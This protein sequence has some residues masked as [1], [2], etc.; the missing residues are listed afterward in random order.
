M[1]PRSPH[2]TTNQPPYALFV[3]LRISSMQPTPWHNIVVGIV[4]HID[5]SDTST[6]IACSLTHP[7]WTLPAQRRLYHTLRIKNREDMCR[8]G[9]FDVRD[10]FTPYVRH[11]IYCGD[12]ENP[13]FP[14]DF[15][16]TCGAK[17]RDF[18][19]HTLEI[20][21]LALERFDVD[22]FMLVFGH[23]R[24]TLRALLIRDATLTLN[25][26]LEFLNLFPLLQCLGLDRFTVV[27][28]PSPFP[29]QRPIFQG[30]LNLSGP[31]KKYGL[32]FIMNLTQMLP[33]FS[34]V[35]LRLNLSYRATR[36]LLE[37][38]RLANNVTTMLLG[39]QTGKLD[40]P[41]PSRTKTDPGVLRR[42]A[43]KYRPFSMLQPPD[44]L[45][46]DPRLV[47]KAID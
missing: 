27:R 24:E 25:K 4:S 45:D 13:L 1:L 42:Y 15:L 35:R 39:Y 9:L 46:S 31:L 17:F 22:L 29:S 2:S 36:R 21:H 47:S 11:L 43:R 23:L 40:L 16:R 14:C 44:A 26:F 7:S 32:R 6:L 5:P 34:S 8:W 30:T 37:V 19:L 12:R 38:P 18:K 41:P 3:V 10:R 33:N 20:R 28:E